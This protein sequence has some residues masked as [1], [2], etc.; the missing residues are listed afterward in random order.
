MAMALFS[1]SFP[2]LLMKEP[3]RRLGCGPD[4][5]RNLRDHLFFRRIDWEKIANREVQPLYRP[6][7][8][9]LYSLDNIHD[10]SC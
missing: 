10:D 2:Q 5:E 3:K 7:I 9:S 1:Y 8:V 4:G 6:P